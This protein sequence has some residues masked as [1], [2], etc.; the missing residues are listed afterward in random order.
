MRTYGGTSRSPVPPTDDIGHG[1]DVA[2][3]A[4]G[5]QNTGP[6][7]T[8]M[9]VAPKAFLGSYKVF[10]TSSG[11]STDAIIEALDDAVSDGMD[12]L[13]LSLGSTI[14]QRTQDDP[15]V[16]AVE[17]A[18]TAGALVTISAGNSGP[19]PNTM[20]SP[21]T[22]PDAITVGSMSNE[23]VFSGALT[24]AGGDPVMAIPGSGPNPST[25]LSAPVID[26]ASVDPTGLA[27][28]SFPAGSLNGSIALILRGSCFFESKLDN[29]AQAG[30]VAALIYAA[31]SSPQAIAMDVG[32]ATLPAAMISNQDGMALKQQLANG[33]PTASI[34]F[35]QKP[36]WAQFQNVSSFSGVGPNVDNGIK[37][38]L[39]AVGDPISTASPM[40]HDGS[41]N[42]GYSIK[43]GTSFSSPIVAGAAA[44][45]KAARPGLTPAQYRSLLVNSGASF[46]S[47]APVAKTGG[48]YL[49]V[50][51]ALQN[52]ITAAPTSL[53]YG[54]GSGTVNQSLT[55]TLTNL[56][57]S[58]DTFALS[59][60]PTDGTAAP[61][62]SSTTLPVAAGQSQTVTLQFNAGSLTAG[63]YDG[64]VQVQGSQTS[65]ITNIPYW[66][67]VASGVAAQVTPLDPPQTGTGGS[68]QAIVFRVTDLIGSAVM[69]TP[70][71]SV[72]SGNGK[73]VGV[74]S[75]DSIIPGAFEA[76]VRL[77]SSGTT[78]VFHIVSGSVSADVTIASQ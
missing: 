21:G 5:V 42:D 40:A 9:G 28:G 71:I 55:V 27:C 65:V 2:M 22:A 33:S 59:V 43:S 4:A 47:P 35:S 63:V 29:V 41:A 31:A 53:S 73:F 11:A 24:I 8:I 14:A 10:A 37:P 67:G 23:R 45:L 1:T 64:Y 68:Q 34:D 76:V 18:F 7:G 62:L 16:S 49:N 57:T 52:T 66:Y 48:G 75:I 12:V 70:T 17:N 6:F 19:D 54:I 78:N 50:A 25:P 20:A 56:G 32:A 61:A 51:A 44:L 38:D 36:F 46:D 30:A 58:D 15:L 69:Q 60:T 72:S 3:C 13:N 74:S 26:V 39:L 77:G